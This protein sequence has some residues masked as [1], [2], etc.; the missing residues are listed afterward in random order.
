MGTS[1]ADKCPV[2]VIDP[3][4]SRETITLTLTSSGQ[5]ASLPDLVGYL[6]PLPFSSFGHFVATLGHLVT[7][8]GLCLLLDPFP[9]GYY[10]NCCF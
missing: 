6:V 2:P 7:I 3:F 5:S 8:Y 9:S 1:S 4:D 10:S